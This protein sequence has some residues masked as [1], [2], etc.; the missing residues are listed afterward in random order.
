MYGKISYKQKQERRERGDCGGEHRR[1]APRGEPRQMKGERTMYKSFE[2]AKEA[3]MDV[4]NKRY[5]RNKMGC[6]ITENK[7]SARARNVWFGFHFYDEDSNG[8]FLRL[9]DGTYCKKTAI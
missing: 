1:T 9:E 3:A 8:K 5:D 6:V 7:S 2:E 4:I